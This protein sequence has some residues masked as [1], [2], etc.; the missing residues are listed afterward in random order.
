MSA[1]LGG[2]VD[3]IEPVNAL[4]RSIGRQP[5]A[6][7]PRH[8]P[9]QHSP[10]VVGLARAGGHGITPFKKVTRN[11]WIIDGIS[12]EVAEGDLDLGDLLQVVGPGVLAKL[13]KLL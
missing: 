8:Q 12:R 1:S 4:W 11:T 7:C 5:A 9:H 3:L 2:A 10:A 13:L 6:T